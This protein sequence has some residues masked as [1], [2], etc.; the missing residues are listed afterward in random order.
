MSTRKKRTGMKTIA[1]LLRRQR[2]KVKK[3]RTGKKTRLRRRLSPV[4][5]MKR[6]KRRK[7]L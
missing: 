6:L 1:S 2:M 5:M 4:R 7:M 3:K